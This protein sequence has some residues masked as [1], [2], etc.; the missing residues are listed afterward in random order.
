MAFAKLLATAGLLASFAVSAVTTASLP[1]IST[2]GSKFYDS[3]GNQFFIKGLSQSP[4]RVNSSN[5]LMT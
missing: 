4:H 2:V 3:N 5:I 1:T